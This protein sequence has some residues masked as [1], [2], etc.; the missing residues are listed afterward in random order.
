VRGTGRGVSAWVGA[1]LLVLALTGGASLKIAAARTRAP[2][3]D[4][5]GAIS[6]FLKQ[7]GYTL[8]DSG[9]EVGSAKIRAVADLDCQV[10]VVQARTQGW[11][12]HAIRH[13]SGPDDNFFVVFQGTTYDRYPTWLIMSHRYWDRARRHVGFAEPARPVLAVIASPTCSIRDLPWQEF[14]KAAL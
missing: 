10:E 2:E 9:D 8:T 3:V 12:Q 13:A 1:L 14:Q 6:Q 5:R 11:D 4:H 7:N